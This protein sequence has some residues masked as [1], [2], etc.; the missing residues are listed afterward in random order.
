MNARTQGPAGKTLAQLLAPLPAPAQTVRGLA[1]DSR[2]LRAGDLFLAC[3]GAEHDARAFIRAA[4]SA[5]AA[6]VVAEA[7]VA[8]GQR[9]QAIPL[10]EVE[11]LRERLGVI[12][13]RFHDHPSDAVVVVGVTGTNGKTTVSQLVGQLLRVGDGSCGVLGTLGA[14][15]DGE[16]A[17]ATHTTPDAITLQRQLARWRDAGIG[18]ASLEVSSHALDQGRINGLRVH[19]AVFTNLSRDHLDY[20]GTMAAYGAAKLRLFRHPGLTQAIVNVD[21]PFAASVLGAL[22]AG[23]RAVTVSTCRRADAEV[24]AD[25]RPQPGALCGTLHT[26]WGTGPV[27]APLLGAFN[28]ANLAAAAASALALGLPFDALQAAVATLRPVPGRMQQ[29]ENARGLRVIVDYAHTPD[30]LDSALAALRVHGAD[31]VLVV[32]GCGGD[33]DRGKR[34]AMGAIACALADRVFVTSDNP[35][36]ED[37]RHILEDVAAGCSGDYRLIVDRAE[38]IRA[39]LA[40]AAPGDAVLIAG[41]GH[42]DYQLIGRERLPFSDAAV[43]RRALEASP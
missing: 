3:R 8:P 17:A 34:A 7:G 41:K 12:A 36:G 43:A 15:T 6:A 18:H 2:L 22:G 27:R 19:T 24:R 4:E 31:R 29:I 11:G 13:A 30:A 9:P 26:P 1:S 20:H 21:D 25:L 39:A 37:P 32:F 42:E 35:R 5:G 14:G 40:A 33:R 16:P 23:V 38:A 28:A 10:V